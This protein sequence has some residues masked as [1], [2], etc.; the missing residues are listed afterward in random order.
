MKLFCAGVGESHPDFTNAS[1]AIKSSEVEKCKANGI[2][3]LEMKVGYDGIVFANS[4]EG[5]SFEVTP[6]L[7]LA[8]LKMSTSRWNS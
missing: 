5:A 6:E 4:K 7:Y 3:V 8:L 1:R 2:K